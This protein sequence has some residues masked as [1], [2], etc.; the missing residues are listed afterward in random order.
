MLYFI[1]SKTRGL[2]RLI[3]RF[4]LHVF[5]FRT[6]T[7]ALISVFKMIFL[8]FKSLN[9]MLNDSTIGTN[10]KNVISQMEPF[11]FHVLGQVKKVQCV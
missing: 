3:T 6:E 7:N 9:Q 8:C 10:S 1:L 5:L 11:L 4:D 2:T